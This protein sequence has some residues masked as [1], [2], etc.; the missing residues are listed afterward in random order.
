[1][2]DIRKWMDAEAARFTPE[3]LGYQLRGL[4]AAVNDLLQ[5]GVPDD[6]QERV[7]YREMLAAIAALAEQRALILSRWLGEHVD[8]CEVARAC[9]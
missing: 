5:E 8:R 1:M 4:T 6:A 7:R 2:E 9:R 3:L